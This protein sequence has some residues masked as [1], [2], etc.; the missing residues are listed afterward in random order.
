MEVYARVNF[1]L[2]L[3]ALAFYAES[4]HAWVVEAGDF[5]VLL[6]SSSRDLRLSGSF[7]HL[8][9]RQLSKEEQSNG[10]ADPAGA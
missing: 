7:H 2:S 4:V 10:T 3:R 6:G 5:N 8:K 9:D 1:R